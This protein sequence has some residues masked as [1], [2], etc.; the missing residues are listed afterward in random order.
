MDNVFFETRNSDRNRK[1]GLVH[2]QVQLL[3]RRN[4]MVYFV[5]VPEQAYYGYCSEALFGKEFTE[6]KEAPEA[7]APVPE[8]LSALPFQKYQ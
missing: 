3:G 5:T 7:P 6:T 2:K 1:A 4:G 8:D